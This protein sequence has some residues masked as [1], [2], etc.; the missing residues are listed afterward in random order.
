MDK[1]YWLVATW[2]AR[3]MVDRTRPSS[4][5]NKPAMVHPPGAGELIR[6]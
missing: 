3:A 4:S 6:T 1:T 5:V 2:I